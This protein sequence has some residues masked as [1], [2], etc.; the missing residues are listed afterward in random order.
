M[1]GATR[2][3][4]SWL[5]GRDDPRVL[6]FLTAENE[7]TER[8]MGRFVALEA[9]IYAEIRSRIEERDRSVPAPRGEYF[10]Y[11]RTEVGKPYRI[12]ARAHGNPDGEEEIYLDENEIAAPHAFCR[13]GGHAVSPDHR[14]VAY[15][16][17][18]TGDE[19][20][21]LR[22]REIATGASLPER[23]ERAAEH[24]AWAADSRT[25][26]YIAR[27]PR[28]RAH[29]VYRHRVG[30]DP[31]EDALVYEEPH[32]AFHLSMRASRS[33]RFIFIEAA[34]AIT[35]E[36]F[37]LDAVH[38]E[39]MPVSVAGRKPGIEYQASD[40]GDDLLVRTNEDA[41]NF[42]VLCAPL[43]D[44]RPK[45]DP[46]SWPQAV[47]HRPH[48]LLEALEPFRDF[49]VLVEREEG[50][51]HLRICPGRTPDG[52]RIDVEESVRTFLTGDNLE[53]ETDRFRYVLSSPVTP[54]TVY[55]VVAATGERTLLKRE[56]VP[57]L[58][59]ARYR[60]ERLWATADDGARIPISLICPADLE[61]TGDNPCLLYGYGA[62]GVCLEPMFAVQV[63]SLVDRGFVH[64]I[65]HVRG[66]G[67]LGEAWHQ[68]GKMLSKR[69]TFTDF[70]SCAERLIET[71]YTSPRR[72]GIQGRS[73]GGLLMG[74]VTNMRPELFGAVV[75]GVPFVDVLATMLDPSIPLTVIEYDE[76]GDPRR[77]EYYDY[78]RSY[79]PFDNV[80]E[81]AYPNMLVTAG[82]NDPRVQFWEPAR[83]VARL[84]ERRTDDKLLLL[85]TDMG[86]G[87][88]G[89][90]DRFEWLREKAFEYAFL[91]GVLAPERLDA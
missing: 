46:A 75:A 18:T 26:F 16:F 49:W 83:W 3:D 85:R 53:F 47:P 63:L 31:S 2:D 34:S 64:A 14:Y 32:E 48:V 9:E 12:W 76:W 91:V 89:P 84:R 66:G 59:P 1:T 56:S 57:G 25:L 88:T 74:A 77:P 30:F 60:A 50:Q 15:V 90:S 17:D 40:S 39:R 38:P 24:L 10:Y 28:K 82:L 70:I 43:E 8:E 58:D 69:T 37:L 80:R 52:Y 35:R 79:S 51:R 22:I 54:P 73:A 81:T 29:R 45:G 72:L 33:R 4:L 21:S 71:G 62:Y 65:A 67:E 68:Q 20:H 23:I 61:Q 6:G 44:G 42:R 7:R 5:R 27:D 11:Y 19:D 86:A 13:V 41:L 87:H 36:S 55:E 78:I